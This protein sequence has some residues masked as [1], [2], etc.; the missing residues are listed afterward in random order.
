MKFHV[1]TLQFFKGGMLRAEGSPQTYAARALRQIF[2]VKNVA[3]LE[4]RVNER[5]PGRRFSRCPATRSTLTIDFYI[6]RDEY[7]DTR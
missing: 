5:H 7:T 3:F 2:P 6:G 4:P 1:I